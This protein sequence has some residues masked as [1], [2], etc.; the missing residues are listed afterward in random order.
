MNNDIGRLAGLYG[1]LQ[2][3]DVPPEAIEIWSVSISH[4][5]MRGQR[6]EEGFGQAF[7]TIW[8]EFWSTFRSKLPS[9]LRHRP[10]MFG[11]AV[12]MLKTAQGRQKFFENA[13]RGYYA[14]KAS[15]V[16]GGSIRKLSAELIML[17]VEK[18]DAFDLHSFVMALGREWPY[19]IPVDQ[20]LARFPNFRPTDPRNLPN[21]GMPCSLLRSDKYATDEDVPSEE[22]GIENPNEWTYVQLITD[23][24]RRLASQEKLDLLAARKEDEQRALE[25]A[26]Q[27]PR[28]TLYATVCTY[29][30]GKGWATAPLN[31]YG[32]ANACFGCGSDGS[33]NQSGPVGF[34]PV[35]DS[36]L[37]FGSW[38]DGSN[39][40]FK[41]TG[42]VPVGNFILC[43]SCEEVF[44]ASGQ[45][46]SEW[47]HLSTSPT[48][49]S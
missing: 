3:L 29:A 49:E 16:N 48:F 20:F 11:K 26:L 39:Y 32:L 13:W 35:S 15:R 6:R 31:P 4:A 12:P 37:C 17:I 47:I 42:L 8:R 7:E 41:P 2:T 28:S 45:V 22:S 38:R 30:V 44:L 10:V 23:A 46:V 19:W 14:F 34:G 33:N 18:L 27:N 9:H 40:Q 25:K 43:V 21:Q 5:Y 24:E 1:L 36:I